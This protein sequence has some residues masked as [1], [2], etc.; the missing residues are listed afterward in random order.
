MYKANRL[1]L[2]PL[3]TLRLENCFLRQQL[4]NILYINRLRLTLADLIVL[5]VNSCIKVQ[6]FLGLGPK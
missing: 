4:L 5:Q 1:S 6:T 3:Q 2:R